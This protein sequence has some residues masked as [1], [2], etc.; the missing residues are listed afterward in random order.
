[1]PIHP[2]WTFLR[3][4]SRFPPLD[5]RRPIE[6]TRVVDLVGGDGTA[7]QRSFGQ[8]RDQIVNMIE[9]SD[10]ADANGF[11]P[12]GGLHFDQNG[13]ILGN[14]IVLGSGNG[15]ADIYMEN[16]KVDGVSMDF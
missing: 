8:D 9:F 3:Q 16:V 4:V 11:T 10:W 13:L 1:M 2:E 15:T 12:G 6:G 7:R 14:S 5:S